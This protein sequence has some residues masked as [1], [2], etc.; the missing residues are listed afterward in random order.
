MATVRVRFVTKQL[1]ENATSPRDLWGVLIATD[2]SARTVTFERKGRLETV[3]MDEADSFC[4]TADDCRLVQKKVWGY[5]DVDLP[6]WLSP[7][8]YLSERERWE[9]SW[10][11]GMPLDW[12]EPWQRF[13]VSV[14]DPDRR[15]GVIKLL[16]AQRLRSPFRISLR[17]QLVEW[18]ETPP[19]ERRFDSPFSPKQWAAVLPWDYRETDRLMGNIYHF[20]PRDR[21]F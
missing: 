18:L 7:E 3:S 21:E 1:G 15:L 20:R 6:D 11:M 5:R 8:E 13:V 4:W 17:K 12:P 10:G 2:P 9:Y 19:E 14:G 16:K